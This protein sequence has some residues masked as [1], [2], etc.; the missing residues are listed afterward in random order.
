MK[1]WQVKELRSLLKLKP[2]VSRDFLLTL[3]G[4]YLFKPFELLS[5]LAMWSRLAQ[6]LNE[7]LDEKESQI[8]DLLASQ[9]LKEWKTIKESY[10][11]K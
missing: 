9:T 7:G 6:K 2:T 4:N 10:G 5:P 1:N 3:E 8:R 11:T